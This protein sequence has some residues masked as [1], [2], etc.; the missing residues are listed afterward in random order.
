MSRERVHRLQAAA[1]G[2]QQQKQRLRRTATGTLPAQMPAKRP[3]AADPHPPGWLAC[4]RP[5]GHEAAALPCS[6][7]HLALA[8]GGSTVSLATAA[9]PDLH[10]A[11]ELGQGL[12]GEGGCA[13]A[14]RGQRADQR[15]RH[16]P[17]LHLLHEP[18]GEELDRH[19]C[20]HSCRPWARGGGRSGIQCW[21]AGQRLPCP[22]AV[23]ACTPPPQMRAASPA[24]CCSDS[25]PGRAHPRPAL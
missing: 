19:A 3:M 21:T 17:Q 13:D 25:I 10:A 8:C 11:H 4:R 23:A 14:Q 22:A 12:A 9:P 18:H 6:Q 1:G 20:R 15:H 7:P 5:E 24:C 2:R 16:G